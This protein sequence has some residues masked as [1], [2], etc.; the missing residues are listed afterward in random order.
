[1]RSEY[2]SLLQRE[3]GDHL[4]WM[5]C[6]LYIYKTYREALNTVTPH[7]SFATQNPPSPAGEGLYAEEVRSGGIV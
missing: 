6:W 7:P 5:R 3:K 2:F 1:M 4:W